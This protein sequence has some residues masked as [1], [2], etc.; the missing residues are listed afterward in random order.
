MNAINIYKLIFL[1]ICVVTSANSYAKS[2]EFPERE[3][4]PTTPYININD[5]HKIKDKVVVVDVRTAYESRNY[6]VVILPAS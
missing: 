1:A 2:S 5:F 6:S 4:Y 3:K